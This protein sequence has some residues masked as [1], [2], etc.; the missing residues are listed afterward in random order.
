MKSVE[1]INDLLA[2]DGLKII[3]RP[4]MFNFS[5]DSLLLGYFS[6]V[7]YKTEKIMDLCT[8]NAPV[9][10]YLTLRT[11]AEIHACEI[12][13]EVYDLAEKSIGM[14]Q[15]EDRIKLYHR[16]LKDIHKDAG[17][18]SFDLVTCNPPYF[19]LRE[20]SNLNAT[21]YKTL[22]RHEVTATLEDI[23]IESKRLL[24]NKGYL[25]MVHR[26]ERLVEIFRVL[27]DHNLTP[28]TVRFIYPKENTN[29]N[30]VIIHAQKD[31]NPGLKVLE[32]IIV[33]E[34]QEYSKVVKEV[35]HYKKNMI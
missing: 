17:V 11:E 13:D 9:A 12:Q 34:G 5:L 28:K 26:P 8:G 2:Y 1:I 6:E 10:M 35:F 15:L 18:N 14:N 30:S 19:K 20:T 23:I 24:K 22:A 29:A 31:A 3:Q 16:N 33:H 21:D 25:A 7:T 27:E 32:P 4:D